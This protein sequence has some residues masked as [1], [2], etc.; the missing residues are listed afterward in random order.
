MEKRIR[1]GG[2][3][4]IMRTTMTVLHV[5]V[6]KFDC[7]LKDIMAREARYKRDGDS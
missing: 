2:M 4:R 5:A 3:G 7:R 6:E 1:S